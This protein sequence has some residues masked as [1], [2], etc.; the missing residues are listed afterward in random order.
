MVK[1][2]YKVIPFE[3]VF[4]AMKPLWGLD[5]TRI[6]EYEPLL[7]GNPAEFFMFTR[8]SPQMALYSNEV[9]VGFT[10]H[11]YNGS[12]AVANPERAKPVKNVS[13]VIVCSAVP[14]H[15]LTF[16]TYHPSLEE[17][18]SLYAGNL[19]AK[20]FEENIS[21]R[22]NIFLN[23]SFVQGHVFASRILE[24]DN[25]VNVINA[26]R[27]ANVKYKEFTTKVNP[28]LK[29]KVENY[30]LESVDEAVSKL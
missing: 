12:L 20:K 6:K 13:E 11:D 9:N 3:E 5:F 1:E 14:E 8:Y 24:E 23:N 28:Q 18:M 19:I 22:R 2:N 25:L 26:V 21:F 27:Q 30:M 4:N 16:D 29:E 17:R 10:L 15:F 7:T